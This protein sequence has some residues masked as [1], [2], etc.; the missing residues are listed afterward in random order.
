MEKIYLYSL[1]SPIIIVPAKTGIIYCNQVNGCSCHA[2]E[3]EGYLIPLSYLN[4]ITYRC[5]DPKMW[6][7]KFTAFPNGVIPKRLK[8]ISTDKMLE[9]YGMKETKMNI[10]QA[11]FY[12]RLENSTIWFKGVIE[13]IE[14]ITDLDFRIKILK[15]V[16]QYEAWMSI[17]FKNVFKGSWKHGI[18]TWQNCD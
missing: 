14:N 7:E 4:P 15:S 8:N 16:R 2:K 17:R 12:D 3:L 9:V 18:L 5:F 11:N 1:D 13:D 6:Y 10:W